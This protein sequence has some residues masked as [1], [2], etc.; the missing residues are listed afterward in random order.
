MVKKASKGKILNAHA[1]TGELI[2][3]IIQNLSA[4]LYLRMDVDSVLLLAEV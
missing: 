2:R 1:R 3:I 4:H